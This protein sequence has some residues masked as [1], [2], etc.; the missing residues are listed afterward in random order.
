MPVR[1]N[2]AFMS[3]VAHFRFLCFSRPSSWTIFW[4]LPRFK[5]LSANIGEIWFLTN[6]FSAIHPAL[7]VL[8]AAYFS[9][10]L[11]FLSPWI[12]QIIAFIQRQG[13]F[14][15]DVCPSFLPSYEKILQKFRLS[16][17]LIACLFRAVPF[18]C[19]SKRNM[20]R[21][22]SPLPPKTSPANKKPRTLWS[23]QLFV[24]FFHSFQCSQSSFS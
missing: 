13:P 19:T 11:Y 16:L 18:A 15:P 21:D 24:G 17:F 9:C 2:V 4:L 6:V 23:A 14:F 1:E 7:K 8:Q 10:R 22:V 20:F 3:Y 5:V 12:K